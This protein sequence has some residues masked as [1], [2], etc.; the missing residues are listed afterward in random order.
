MERKTCEVE[1]FG[2]KV[3]LAE[4]SAMDVLDV[5]EAAQHA[6]DITRE[7]RLMAVVISQSLLSANKKER[8]Y[9]PRYLLSNLSPAQISELSGKVFELEGFV[10]DKKKVTESPSQEKSQEQQ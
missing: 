1:L 7:L 8:K 3:L 2:R 5:L 10:D 6:K 9:K 4:R